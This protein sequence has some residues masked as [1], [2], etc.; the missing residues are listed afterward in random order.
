VKAEHHSDAKHQD[1]KKHEHRDY[2]AGGFL[3]RRPCTVP[4]AGLTL[5][6]GAVAGAAGFLGARL[7]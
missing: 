1:Q 4:G 2:D 5:R 6:T 3:L 7:S